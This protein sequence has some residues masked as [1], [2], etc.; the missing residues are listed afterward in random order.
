MSTAARTHPL[1]DE[2]SLAQVRAPGVGRDLT[3]HGASGTPAPGA[4]A[5]VAVIRI[6]D[7]PDTPR[8]AVAA[9]GH[10]L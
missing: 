7:A 5:D 6:A 9:R 8:G 4:R 2:A 3:G 10:P 1:R